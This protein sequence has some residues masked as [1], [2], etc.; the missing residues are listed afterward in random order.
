M[1]G[2]SDQTPRRILVI[3]DNEAIH[4]DLKKAL[5]NGSRSTG[6]DDLESA[7]FGTPAST[8]SE[9]VE[10]EIDSA[11]QGLDGVAKVKEARS[12]S[13]PYMLAFV[14]MRM[15]PG[16]DGVD[17]ID[18][19]WQ[20]DPDLQVV[21]CTAYS[22]YSWE[23]MVRKL[24]LTDRMLII[25]KPFDQAEVCQAAAAMCEKWR[26]TLQTKTNLEGM[27]SLV[28]QR[29]IELRQSNQQLEIEIAERKAAENQ[30]RHDALHDPLTHLPN[31]TLLMERLRRAIKRSERDPHHKFAVL[32]L[33][34]DNFK[35][36]NDSLGH[37]LGDEVLITVAQR[38]VACVRT[39]D[40]VVR[41][42]EDTTA[43]LGGDEFV[44]LLEGIKAAEDV[45]LVADRLRD[46]L[47]EPINLSGNDLV[48]SSSIGISVS[49]GEYTEPEDILRDADTAMYRAKAGGKARYAIFN[50]KMHYEAIVA[51]AAGDR[52][53]HGGRP[54]AVLRPLPADRQ[55]R[56]RL[57]PRLRGAASLES[58]ESRRRFRIA[59]GDEELLDALR[60]GQLA[61]LRCHRQHH[62]GC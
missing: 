61:F 43:R 24:G 54:E 19:I 2:S 41:Q 13:R 60:E 37:A 9:S 36:I 11:F 33:D 7:L 53:P 62:Q 26:L 47:Q 21:V 48:I 17:T 25:K 39:M 10:Y 51:P 46:H 58:S 34:V 50:K 31:R 42:D 4:E 59:S 1:N 45:I 56:R 40:T 52:S 8:V 14:D 12:A 30:L 16:I 20:E 5:R 38:L 28:E 35:I 18:R 15:P 6:L 27:E 49:D 57:D 23:D 32:F 29:T 3:D 22:D 55:S 44:I